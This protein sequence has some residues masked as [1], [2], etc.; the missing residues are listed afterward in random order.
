MEVNF[1]NYRHTIKLIFSNFA[2]RSKCYVDKIILLAVVTENGKV[3]QSSG[4]DELPPNLL[5]DMAETIWKPLSFI[6]NRS[7]S[8]GEIPSPLK[9]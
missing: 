3:Q 8:T 5:E 6:I 2:G 4:I 1:T 7:L 9:T